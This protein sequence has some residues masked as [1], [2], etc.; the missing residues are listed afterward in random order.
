MLETSGPPPADTVVTFT[1]G[2]PRAIV[3]RSAST[4]RNPSIIRKPMRNAGGRS[5]PCDSSVQSHAL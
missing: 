3:I 2:E 4:S 1:A 5:P